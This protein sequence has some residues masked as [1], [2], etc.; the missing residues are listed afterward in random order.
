MEGIE[1]P[2]NDWKKKYDWHQARINYLASP[3]YE[4]SDFVKQELGLSMSGNT[5]LKTTGW[6]REKDAMKA[7]A[8]ER[9]K[10]QLIK[11]QVKLYKPSIEEL[12][13]MHKG[14]IQL[15]QLSLQYLNEQ[16]IKIDPKTWKPT[17]VRMPDTND[18]TR[19]WKM[20]KAEKLEPESVTNTNLQAT[21]E[22]EL[23][24]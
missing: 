23:E 2:K 15:M 10:E 19:L 8:V 4:V 6:Q 24:E 13:K 9:A 18:T 14:V 16:C 22:I 7:E 3:I 1:R 20:I 17:L 11:E 5:T 21:S 12:N